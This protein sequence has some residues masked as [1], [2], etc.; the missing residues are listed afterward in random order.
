MTKKS[1]KTGMDFLIQES[2]ANILQDKDNGHQ[3]KPKLETIRKATF[4]FDAGHLETIKAIA[5]YDRKKIGEVLDEALVAY[6]KRYPF[7]D[8]AQDIYSDLPNKY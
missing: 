1:F 5:Y 7:V 6:I 4:R 2:K 8:Q 3:D